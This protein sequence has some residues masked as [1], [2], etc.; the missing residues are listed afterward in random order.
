[1]EVARETLQKDPNDAGANL[2]LGR[3][4]CLL[5]NDW[6]NGLPHFAKGSDVALKALAEQ[7]LAGDL[8]EKQQTQLA[9]GW[10]DFAQKEADLEREGAR[11]HAAELYRI[12]LPK[13]QSPLK[14]AMI[15]QRLVEL[16]TI[17]PH[18]GPTLPATSG[19]PFAHSQ[20]V[21]LLRLS[22][23][24]A[25]A[26]YGTWSRKGAELMCEPAEFARI[27][28]P[29]EINAS[30]DLEVEFT[31]KEGNDEL[32]AI[33]PVAGHPCMVMLSAFDGMASGLSRVGGVS[34]A[35]QKQY[36]AHPGKIENDRRYRL[37][38]SVRS[39][40]RQYGEY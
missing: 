2:T 37:L 23:P 33:I 31:R 1:M 12:A 38:I 3:W 34:I 32:N 15:Q 5:K 10:W 8:D 7:E 40:Q 36:A 19:G 18:G 16:A 26:I 28:F 14:Q 21:D 35:D 39:D 30:Y 29:I 22:N 11:Q 20:W 6:S 13:S 17:Q 4:L 24:T 9:D 25:D 27:S